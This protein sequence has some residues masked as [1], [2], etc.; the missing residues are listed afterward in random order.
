MPDRTTTGLE[1]AVRQM[2]HEPG[3]RLAFVGDSVTWGTFAAPG[4]TLPAQ[5]ERVAG[6]GAGVRAFNL[7]L[8]AAHAV[9]VGGVVQRVLDA[10]AADV[11]VANFDYR[12]YASD[13]TTAVR[14]PELYDAPDAPLVPSGFSARSPKPDLEQRIG[15]ALGSVWRLWDQRGYL[16]LVMLNGAP[17]EAA[18]R[19]W[20]R[21]RAAMN[22]RPPH[23]K[24]TIEELDPAKLRDAYAVDP[25]TQDNPHIAELGRMIDAANRDGVPFVLVVGPVDSAMLT[26]Q[27]LWDR[28]AYE[29]NIVWLTAYAT[30]RGALVLDHTDAVPP[31]LMADTHHPLPQGYAVWAA[32]L[33]SDIAELIAARSGSGGR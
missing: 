2:A 15:G 23:R 1:Q 14:Y 32:R 17:R 30:Q 28:A 13:E 4:E 7:A 5:F 22:G 29:Q 27:Q 24:K 3:V 26:E 11:I 25:Y 16:A 8:P 18:E 31:E 20:A 33:R 12:F 9:D 10:H 19:E 6:P 21:T